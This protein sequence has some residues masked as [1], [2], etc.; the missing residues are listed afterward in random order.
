MVVVTVGRAVIVGPVGLAGDVAR[1]MRLRVGLAELGGGRLVARRGRECA[2]AVP[3]AERLS[4]AL[5]KTEVAGSIP[6]GDILRAL[7][8]YRTRRPRPVK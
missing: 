3:E 6:A 2:G 4:T 8:A 5:P 7:I 1:V